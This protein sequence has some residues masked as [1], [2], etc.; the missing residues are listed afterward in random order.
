MF[1]DVSAHQFH[2]I[3]AVVTGFAAE[4]RT[5]SR[6]FRI[7]RGLEKDY[8]SGIGTPRRTSGAAIDFRAL[9]RIIELVPGIFLPREDRS[10]SF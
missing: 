4:T 9:Y 1:F 6:L 3:L 2:N 10:P 7:G 8:V 5:K